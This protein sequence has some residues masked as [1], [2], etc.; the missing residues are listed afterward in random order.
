MYIRVSK[1]LFA[2][3]CFGVCKNYEINFYCFYDKSMA[4][5]FFL[6]LNMQDPSMWVEDVRAD[7]KMNHKS[8]YKKYVLGFSSL[9][10][11]IIFFFLRTDRI[12]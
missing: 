10:V 7:S 11:F 9:C 2:L 8:A 12:L 1:V 4:F 5:L 3:I 6:L